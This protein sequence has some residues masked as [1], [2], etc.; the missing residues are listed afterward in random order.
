MASIED[1]RDRH[2]VITGGTGAL[3]SAV[4]E[5]LRASGA[6]CHLPVR[7]PG[8]PAP[9]T[10]LVTPGVDLTDEAAVTRFF[11]SLPSLWASVHVAGGYAA[12][13]MLES[14]L[15]MLRQQV[16]LNL[17][18]AF[19]CSREAVRAMRR[20]GKGG[21]IVNTAS[22]AAVTPAAGAVAYAASKAGV[23]ALTSSL[24]PEVRSD[25]ILVNAIAPAII[26]TP[27]NRAA[28]P[29][30]DRTTWASP[31]AIAETIAWLISP[32]NTLISGA[33]VPV[34]GRA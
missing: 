11:A 23:V 18:T 29:N 4:V 2:V 27:D 28:M 13:P 20:S 3:G 34:Y 8:A 9:A 22:R 33:V 1:L 14:S 21:R 17:V 31:A 16:D 10:V 19:L 6:I 15:A 30:A 7:R 26:D 32:R 24:A 12:A 5:V 25:R